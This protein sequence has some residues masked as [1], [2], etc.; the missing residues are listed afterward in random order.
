[1]KY[2]K[3]A[4]VPQETLDYIGDIQVWHPEITILSESDFNNVADLMRNK[5]DYWPQGAIC[6]AQDEGGPWWAYRDI[7]TATSYGWKGD[8]I[9]S[10]HHNGQVIGNW[11]NTLFMKDETPTKS[12]GSTAS[13]YELPAG[14]TQLQNLISYRN[15]NA[16]DGLASH[17]DEL[18]DAKKVLFYAQAEVDR[19]EALK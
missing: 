15:M 10:V 2:Q 4:D 19:L 14:A 12:D 9:G 16:Q 3:L 5:P 7:P 13:Y 18:R 8:F 6:W 11:G 17:S 1:M